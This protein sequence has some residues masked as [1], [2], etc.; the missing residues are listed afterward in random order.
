MGTSGSDSCCFICVH[1]CH[2]AAALRVSRVSLRVLTRIWEITAGELQNV[3]TSD[4]THAKCMASELARK[5]DS[6]SLRRDYDARLKTHLPMP[7]S[8]SCTLYAIVNA[9]MD[10]DVVVIE[11][12]HQICSVVSVAFPWRSARHGVTRSHRRS[13]RRNGTAVVCHH[14]R[15]SAVS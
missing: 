8:T 15:R 13:G 9:R 1:G 10:A 11:W 2:T 7:Q 5:G 14:A 3:F 6:S 12:W 4:V